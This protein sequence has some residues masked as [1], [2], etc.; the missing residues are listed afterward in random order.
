M[1]NHITHDFKV[2]IKDVLKLILS[3]GEMTSKRQLSKTLMCNIN[4]KINNP[5]TL[6]KNMILSTRNIVC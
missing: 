1:S 6:G 3:Q 2:L 5:T 4:K